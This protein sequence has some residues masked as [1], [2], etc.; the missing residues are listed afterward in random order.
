MKR[1]A[2]FVA[3]IA[4]AWAGV[5]GAHEVQHEIAPGAAVV[6]RLVYADGEPFAYEQYELFAKGREQPVQ[7]GRTD[8]KGRVLFASDDTTSWRLRSFSADGHGVDLN[9][10]ARADAAAAPTAP[11]AADPGRAMRLLSGLAVI[12]V[13][14]AALA[15]LL[16]R[17]RPA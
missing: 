16:R 8:Y 15:L 10:D 12:L 4:F 5:A 9:F 1:R 2:Q 6:V 17:R 11:V 3:A 13:T 14:F 7:T